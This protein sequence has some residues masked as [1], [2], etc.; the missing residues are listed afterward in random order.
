MPGRRGRAARGGPAGRACGRGT[1]RR[2]EAVARPEPSR[3]IRS[4][5]CVSLV[6]RSTSD[7]RGGVVVAIWSDRIGGLRSDPHPSVVCGSTLASADS[8]CTGNPSAR[9]TLLDVRRQRPRS[10]ARGNDTSACRRRNVAAPSGPRSG[11]RR[12]SAARGWSPRRSR[13]RRSPPP[14]PTNTQPAAHHRAGQIARLR[15]RASSR[16][17]G[18]IAFGELDGRLEARHLRPA[19][20]ERPR[21]ARSRGRELV[22]LATRTCVEQRVAR[23]Q[24]HQQ[25]VRAVLG[26]RREVERDQRGVGLPVGDHDQLARPGD[27]VDADHAR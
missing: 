14:R 5:I 25:A 21:R 7:D 24:Q 19:P 11:P 8:A 16:C 3:A 18:A 9:A 26:L 2:C 4:R 12:R 23:A 15:R 22:Q 10:R 6:D 20:R 27:A 17:S 1:R 13:R